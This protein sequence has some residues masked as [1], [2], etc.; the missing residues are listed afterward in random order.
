M[1]GHHPSFLL[2]RSICYISLPC[3][4]TS[5]RISTIRAGQSLPDATRRSR[6]PQTLLPYLRCI[7]EFVVQ[8]TSGSIQSTLHHRVPLLPRPPNPENRYP[9]T[10]H[11]CIGAKLRILLHFFFRSSAPTTPLIRVPTGSPILLIKT[12]ALS[13][14]RIT[15]PSFLPTLYFVRTTTAC[16]ISPRLTF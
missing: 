3:F 9:H 4:T 12:H 10:H 8:Y 11:T 6:T 1:I 15:L 7:L 2:I 14:N 16:R 13:S 5:T